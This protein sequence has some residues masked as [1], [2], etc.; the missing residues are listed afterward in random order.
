M[1]NAENIFKMGG[2]KREGATSVCYR[3]N[4]EQDTTPQTTQIKLNLSRHKRNI[5]LQK[6]LHNK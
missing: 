6:Y 4:I 5:D 2:K 1:R 3:N